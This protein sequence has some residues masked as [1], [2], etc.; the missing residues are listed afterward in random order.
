MRILFVSPIIPYPPVQG[1][2]VVKWT[3]VRA[4][5]SRHQ[6]TLLFRYVSR[7]DEAHFGV[8]AKEFPEMVPVPAP[9][10]KSLLHRLGYK[11]GYLL[12]SAWRGVPK[13]AYYDC[14]RVLVER[15]RELH[16]DRPFDLVFVN[17]WWLAP[18]ARAVDAPVRVLLAH[19][20][21][22]LT[23]RAKVR[24]APDGWRRLW[25][26]LKYHMIKKWEL[27][28]FTPFTH[29]ATLTET[30]RASL[31][32]SMPWR[33]R[34]TFGVIPHVV[35]GERFPSA[36][37][38]SGKDDLLYMGFLQ[39]DFNRDGLRYFLAGIYPRI[40]EERPGAV[41]TVIGGEV[42][43]SWVSHLPPE[44]VRLEGFVRDHRPYLA[45]TAVMVLPLRFAGGLRVRLLEALAAETPVVCTP[46]AARGAGVE[47]GKHYLEADTPES[48]A[49]GVVRLL[50]DRELGQALGRAGRDHVLAVHGPEAARNR[51]LE[52]IGSWSRSART[53]AR[54]G[55][56]DM[57]RPEGGNDGAARGGGER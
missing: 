38:R 43:A 15:A 18:V 42:P 48:F 23:S 32:A 25:R 30:D 52:L 27:A 3:V 46:E 57:A 14:P 49:S 56:L 9:N 11:L 1:T 36:S 33:P 54:D 28:A 39:A 21:D 53:G 44:S 55:G 8:M 40:L 4:L 24:L 13:R 41:L 5:A 20:V 12:F 51:I 26:R 17:Y 50:V 19:D 31:H 35:E 7:E 45:E 29:I 47:A 34:E 16:R 37:G 2:K 10:R 22:H 6:V